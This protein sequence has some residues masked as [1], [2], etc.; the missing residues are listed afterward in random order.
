MDFKKMFSKK[1][2]FKSFPP[3]FDAKIYRNRYADLSHFSKKKLIDHYNAY[4]KNEGRICSLVSNRR[5][6]INSTID[7]ESPVLEIGPFLNPMLRRPEF[8]VKYFDILD[9][10]SLIKRAKELIE[11][12]D[13]EK[14]LLAER[15][16]N[17][18]D[19]DFSN[20][21]GDLSTVPEKFSYVFSCH[22]I[23][24]QVDFIKHL[25]QVHDLLVPGGKYCMV[26]PDKRYCF[27]YYHPESRAID[28]IAAH[29][30]KRQFHTATKVLE[31]RFDLT[32]NDPVRHWAGDHGVQRRLDKTFT[33]L[34]NWFESVLH[35]ASVTDHQY[36]DVHNWI[37]T[38]DSF[39]SISSYLHSTG[40][41]KFA[42]ERLYPTL[43]NTMEF[44]VVFDRC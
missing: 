9:R 22:N 36:I 2:E 19:I 11:I 29:I 6:F 26:V 31:H 20:S 28:M 37:V 13:P 23:E 24:H 4:G 5:A 44:Y 14:E 33:D 21:V 40:F 25:N 30:E 7:N 16:V 39:Q 41:I 12:N 35:E 3:E 43:W 15:I 8:N 38:P 27:D 17:A 34:P 42:I 1:N 10:D 32:H 18:P